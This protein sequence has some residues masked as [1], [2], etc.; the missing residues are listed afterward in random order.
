MIR[1]TSCIL[2]HCLLFDFGK[3]NSSIKAEK[4]YSKSPLRY[5]KIIVWWK[6][7][8]TTF[9]PLRHCPSSSSSLSITKGG[10]RA[11]TTLKTVRALVDTA[12]TERSPPGQIMVSRRTDL[13]DT[14]PTRF[15]FVLENAGT[16]V[17]REKC[18]FQYTILMFS[19]MVRVQKKY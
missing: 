1:V 5:F 12:A 8:A 3:N 4:E 14:I 15:H 19:N 16:S 13:P 17:E 11:V 18:L 10:A 6:L 2:E 9:L 7:I